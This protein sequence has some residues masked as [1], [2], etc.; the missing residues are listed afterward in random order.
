MVVEQ[1]QQDSMH[2]RIKVLLGYV[3]DKTK[4]LLLL[5]LLL[6]LLIVHLFIGLI[7]SPQR[8]QRNNARTWCFILRSIKT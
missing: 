5:L 8:E 7:R 6:L 3:G 2:S 4:P 1:Q